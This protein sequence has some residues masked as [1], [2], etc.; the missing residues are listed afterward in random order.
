MEN[1]LPDWFVLLPR[2]M[3]VEATR[4]ICSKLSIFFVIGRDSKKPPG[5]LT[6]KQ[7]CLSFVWHLIKTSPYFG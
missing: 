3:F 7:L 6:Q 1:P 4:G 5:E 2:N